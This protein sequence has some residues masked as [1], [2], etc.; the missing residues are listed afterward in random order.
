MI[1][2]KIDNNLKVYNES[3]NVNHNNFIYDGAD[4]RCQQFTFV[5][6]VLRQVFSMLV[7]HN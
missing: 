6:Y 3:I 1:R 2:C 7:G 5:F 4:W